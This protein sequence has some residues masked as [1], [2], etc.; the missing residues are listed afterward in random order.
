MIYKDYCNDFTFYLYF[1]NYLYLS[2]TDG[3]LVRNRKR[4]SHHFPAFIFF[5]SIMEF[6]TIFLFTINIQNLLYSKFFFCFQQWWWNLLDN[7][8]F[9]FIYSIYHFLK[10]PYYFAT[11]CFKVNECLVH[12]MGCNLQGIGKWLEERI[13]YA[14][15]Y[16]VKGHLV[17]TELQHGTH[18]THL[19]SIRWTTNGLQEPWLYQNSIT[20]AHSFPL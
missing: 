15:L 8:L 16:L 14:L 12:T 17:E 5:I 4:V 7:H 6:L 1:R 18:R 2:F 20:F 3:T 10:R 13:P 9:F 11:C 19:A